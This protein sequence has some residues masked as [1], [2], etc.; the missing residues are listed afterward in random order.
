LSR[1]V[2][3]INR[4]ELQRAASRVIV[5]GQVTEVDWSLAWTGYRGMIAETVVQ[6][7]LPETRAIIELGSGWGANLLNVWLRGGPRL[8]AY[9]AGEVTENG[10]RCV[11]ALAAVD[12]SLDLRV[13]P[14]D[15]NQP[16]FSPFRSD[17]HVV[18]FTVH[19]IEQIPQLS[20]DVIQGV[21]DLA[22]RVTGLHFEPIGWQIGKSAG[23][24]EA[25][26]AR[27]DYNRN[28]WSVLRDFAVR[29]SLLIERVSVDEIGLNPKNSTTVVCWHKNAF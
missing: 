14:F 27:H 29:Q 6:S 3:A 20:S 1:A 9:Y 17:G 28:L 5:G 8:A 11:A 26:A 21:L 16:D 25:Y 4:N 15:F 7:C 12:S 10:R 22:P 13:M 19:S 24:S 2:A 18:V 23:S